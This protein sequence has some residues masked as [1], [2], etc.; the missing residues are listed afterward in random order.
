LFPAATGNPTA[1]NQ[2]AQSIVDDILTAPGTKFSQGLRPRFGN[3]IEVQAPD[4]RGLV[5]DENGRFLFFK[6]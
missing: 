6:E 3:T 5:F 4:G 1:I 2:Q